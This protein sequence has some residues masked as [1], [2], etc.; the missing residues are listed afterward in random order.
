MKIDLEQFEY[1]TVYMN[2]YM[3]VYITYKQ[4]TVGSLRLQN[5][6]LLIAAF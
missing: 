3:H 5:G 4:Y 6:H 2:E 1:P